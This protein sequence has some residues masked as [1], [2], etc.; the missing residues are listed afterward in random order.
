[1]EQNNY[2]EGKPISIIIYEAKEKLTD[3]I[4]D[5]NI[6]PSILE[7]IIRE[8]YEQVI[9]LKQQELQRDKQKYQKNSKE[10]STE[11]RK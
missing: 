4:N 9:Q 1:M 10:N 5:L 7:P 6:S 11:E 2:S 8:L 3:T